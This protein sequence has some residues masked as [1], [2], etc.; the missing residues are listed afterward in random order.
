M[1]QNQ[2]PDL[3]AAAYKLTAKAGNGQGVYAYVCVPA[4]G[5]RETHPQ[6]R[7][8]CVNGMSY[9]GRAEKNANSAVIV[10]VTPEDFMGENK[11]PLSGIAFQ[12]EWKSGHT[13]PERERFPRPVLR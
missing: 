11:D 4:V 13:G 8:L 12:R 3:P 6:K 2:H 5:C 9:H 1:E 7:R 10:T